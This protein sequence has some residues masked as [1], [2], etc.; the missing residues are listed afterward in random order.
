MYRTIIINGEWD[1]PNFRDSVCRETIKLEIKEESETEYEINL[2]DDPLTVKS[3][4]GEDVKIESGEI[5]TWG[6]IYWLW[7]NN[8]TWN[9]RRSTSDLRFKRSY[10]YWIIEQDLHVDDTTIEEFKIGDN[11]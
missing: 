3:E 9:E 11:R 8:Q 2:S 10:L 5:R 4:Y 7:R 1:C 6:W